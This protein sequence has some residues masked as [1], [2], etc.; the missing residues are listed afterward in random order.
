MVDLFNEMQHLKSELKYNKTE[1][2]IVNDMVEKY[3]IG[4]EEHVHRRRYLLDDN[5]RL[6]KMIRTITEIS[7]AMRYIIELDN[8]VSDKTIQPE[9]YTKIIEIKKKYTQR[10]QKLLEF[11]KHQ[12]EVREKIFN[13]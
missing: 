10:Y 4:G 1:L 5:H 6:N 2:V 8:E 13:L 11:Y 12:C 9:Q 7:N 3:T